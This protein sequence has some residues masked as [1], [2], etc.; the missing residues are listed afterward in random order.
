MSRANVSYH[1]LQLEKTV[2]VQLIRRT[3]REIELTEVGR[4]IYEHGKNIQNEMLALQDTVLNLGQRLQGRVGLSVPS[5]Y[6]DM[7]MSDWLLAFK[8]RYPGIV[9][10]VMFENRAEILRDDVDIAVRIAPEPPASLVA[11]KLG[12]VRYLACASRSW[13]QHNPAP[14]TLA[15]LHHSPVISA[16]THYRQLRLAAYCGA[17]RQ[18]VMLAPVLISAHFPFL[19]KAILAGLGIGIV[20][21][22]VVQAE[23]ANGEVIVML[24]DWRLSIFGANMYMLHMPGVR[25]TRAVQTCIQFLKECAQA[26]AEQEQP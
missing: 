4:R 16:D 20:P 19:R 11:H 23:I 26:S 17:E 22:Y 24:E 5:G 12:T 15:D 10:D 8:A 14:Q 3:T 21:D 18:E 7:V 1:L 13:L 9:L 6:G 25:Q 2:G